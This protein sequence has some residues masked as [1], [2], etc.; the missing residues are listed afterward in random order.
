MTPND[1][2]EREALLDRLMTDFDRFMQQMA[3][4]HAPEF[5]EVGLTMSQ[6]KVLYLVQASTP[7]GLSE[8]A[9]RL[10]VTVSTASG[11]VERVVE[12]GLLDRRDDPADRRHVLLSVTAGGTARLDHMRELNARQMRLIL[13]RVATRDLASIDRAIRVLSDAAA[14]LATNASPTN[15]PAASPAQEEPS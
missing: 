5:S 7:I 13:E 6:A 9:S 4:S 11:L 3:A 2:T 1:T 8:L 12:A 10:G 14:G 15:N